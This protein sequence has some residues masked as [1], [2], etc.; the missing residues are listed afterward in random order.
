MKRLILVIGILLILVIFFAG[1]EGTTTPGTGTGVSGSFRLVLFQ[2]PAGYFSILVPQGVTISNED[3]EL[4]SDYVY[5][6]LSD[7][8]KNMVTLTL[9]DFSSIPW[10]PQNLTAEGFANL[11]TLGI[12]FMSEGNEFSNLEGPTEYGGGSYYTATL[13]DPEIGYPVQFAI[14]VKKVAELQF[15]SFGVILNNEVTKSV[16]LQMIDSFKVLKTL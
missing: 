3:T 14:F 15:A 2:D 1:C 6:Q 11:Q 8:T 16:F 5:Y 7:G 9:A 12:L 10:L 4:E 13:N